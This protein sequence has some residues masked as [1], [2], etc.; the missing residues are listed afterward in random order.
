MTSTAQSGQPLPGVLGLVFFGFPLHPP[1]K[2]GTERAAHLSSAG[3]PM[4]FLQGT[5]DEFA[6]LDLLEPLIE[7]LGASRHFVEGADHS[8]RTRGRKAADVVAELADATEA[9][10]TGN[11]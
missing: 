1:G 8:F 4:L 9:W 3:V 2:P 10:V 7:S 11:R 6:R 5:R